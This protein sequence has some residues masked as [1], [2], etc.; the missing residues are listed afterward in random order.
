MVINDILMYAAAINILIGHL[1]TIMKHFS[2]VTYNTRIHAVHKICYSYSNIAVIL[3][4][5]TN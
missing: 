2:K 5:F 4:F 3:S 1:I